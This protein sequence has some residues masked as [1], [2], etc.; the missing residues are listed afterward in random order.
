[1]TYI[2]CI[3]KLTV[4]PTEANVELPGV[5]KGLGAFIL[6][7]STACM[8]L[9]VLLLLLLR[10][11]MIQAM[12]RERIHSDS[13]LQG[14]LPESSVLCTELPQQPPTPTAYLQGTMAGSQLP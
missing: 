4:L 2:N 12:L 11:R 6:S 5:G 13:S 10:K 7:A 9:T 3:L 8:E 1:M 14:H